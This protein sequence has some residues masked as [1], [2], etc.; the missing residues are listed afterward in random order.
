MLPNL[1]VFLSLEEEDES[2]SLDVLSSSTVEKASERV[3]VKDSLLVN[4]F[5]K[6]LLSIFGVQSLNRAL[7]Q[8]FELTMLE[9]VDPSEH[10]PAMIHSTVVFA[11]LNN[12]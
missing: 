9:F 12:G 10:I 2:V 7:G 11:Q 8:S 3:E 5:I 6:K 1:T 4:F